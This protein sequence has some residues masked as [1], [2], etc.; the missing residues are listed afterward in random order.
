MK[1]MWFKDKLRTELQSSSHIKIEMV[2]SMTFCLT[3]YGAEISDAGLY[4]VEVV[5]IRF[6]KALDAFTKIP[7]R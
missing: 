6:D 5:S 7:N 4:Q 3:I 1:V 2:D